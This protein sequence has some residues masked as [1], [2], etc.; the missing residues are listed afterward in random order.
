VVSTRVREDYAFGQQ[1]SG[2]VPVEASGDLDGRALD[3]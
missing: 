2:S 1:I 3:V